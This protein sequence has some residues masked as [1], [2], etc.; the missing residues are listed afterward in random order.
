[1]NLFE[2]NLLHLLD[3]YVSS[4]SSCPLL[5]SSLNLFS[6]E[7]DVDFKWNVY[8]FFSGPQTPDVDEIFSK[9]LQKIKRVHPLTV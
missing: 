3:W 7:N 4:N 9:Y 1:M 6:P 8:V 5:A 2:E